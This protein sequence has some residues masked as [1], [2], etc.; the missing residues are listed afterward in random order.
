MSILARLVY[1][2]QNLMPEPIGAFALVLHSHLPYVLAHDRLEEEWLFEAVTESYLP[3]VQ[4]FSQFSLR[5]IAP[6]VTIGVTPVLLEQLADP[7]F[8][9]QFLAYVEQKVQCAAA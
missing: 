2:A 4:V 9:T 7:R 3:L 6:K 1:K 8:S 5:G